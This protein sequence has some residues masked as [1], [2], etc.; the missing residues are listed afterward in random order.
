VAQHDPALQELVVQAARDSTAAGRLFELHRARLRRMIDLRLDRRLQGRLDASDVLQESFVEFVR[1]LPVYAT[2]PQAPFYLW[3][4]CIAD[5]KL[6]ALHRK[7][8]GTRM[9]GAGREVSLQGPAAAEAGSASLAEFL[10][11]RLT[12]PSQAIARAEL[13][14]HI[15]E[16]L[17]QLSAADREV[18]A[19]R[20]YEQLSN[21][22]TSFVLGT[23]EATASVRYIRALR[24]LK[25][26]LD[27]VPGLLAD[28][29]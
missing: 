21:Q 22:E 28:F 20:H 26:A 10:L 16:A 5:R 18:L 24:R 23:S 19:L 1:A 17:A 11:G 12:T 9:R 7:H 4:R 2:N 13:Q 27:N 25:R 15:Q 8:L 29:A 6:Q 14:V 3:L